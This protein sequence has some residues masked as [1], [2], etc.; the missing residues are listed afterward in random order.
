[1][2]H[3]IVFPSDEEFPAVTRA[4][5][6]APAGQWGFDRDA[7]HASRVSR[8]G[9]PTEEGESVYTTLRACVRARLLQRE[10]EPL[11]KSLL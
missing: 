2:G 3:P 5:R 8:E 1:M 6:D 4:A 11:I 7:T 9:G 10:R